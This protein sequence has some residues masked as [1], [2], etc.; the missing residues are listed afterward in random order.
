V[1]PLVELYQRTPAIL[2]MRGFRDAE[3]SEPL[4]LL[5]MTSY[6]GLEGFELARKQ[7]SAN[8]PATVRRS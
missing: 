4:D 1:D 2:R 8:G 3:S 5:L 6:R 7:W